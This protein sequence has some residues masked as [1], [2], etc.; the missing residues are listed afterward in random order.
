[1]AET[2]LNHVP[3]ERI[4][5]VV[6]F[7]PDDLA[8]PIGLNLLEIDEKLDGDALLRE[9]DLI[10]ETIV[11]IFRKVFSDDDSGGHRIEYMLRN[12]VQTALTQEKATLF[13]VYDL[14]NDPTYRKKVV[15][16]L[17]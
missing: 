13:T 15:A 1:M 12:A 17:R 6:Y 8:Y 16:S 9:K 7:N 14:I 5:D 11:S 10:T 3:K 2:L 4:K